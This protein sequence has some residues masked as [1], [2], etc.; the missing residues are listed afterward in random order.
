MLS[1][2]LLVDPVICFGHEPEVDLRVYHE[3]EASW[4][5]HVLADHSPHSTE[6]G[7]V[8][9]APLAPN[10]LVGSHLGFVLPVGCVG[11]LLGQVFQLLGA[12]EV[13]EPH[14]GVE[15]AV[16]DG[17]PR[18]SVDSEGQPLWRELE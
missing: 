5:P 6:K 1:C 3:L 10:N 8:Q 13:H 2:L 12:G 16:G 15:S 18:V 9:L 17:C 11:H 7:Q 14:Q 4:R